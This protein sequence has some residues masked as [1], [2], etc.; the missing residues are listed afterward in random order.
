MVHLRYGLLRKLVVSSKETVVLKEE[1]IGLSKCFMLIP[2]LVPE[3][4][5]SWELVL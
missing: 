1:V 5:E 3:F 2:G 4:L